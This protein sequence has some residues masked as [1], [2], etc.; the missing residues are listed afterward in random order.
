MTRLISYYMF[1][2]GELAQH[3]RNMETF[4]C[5]YNWPDWLVYHLTGNFPHFSQSF[6]CWL[7]SPF[8]KKK[9]TLNWRT[10]RRCGCVIFRCPFSLY[11]WK[12]HN[13]KEPTCPSLSHCKEYCVNRFTSCSVLASLHKVPLALP[14][15]SDIIPPGSPIRRC[16][17]RPP[18]PHL[19]FQLVCSS[20][21]DVQNTFQD[22]G[23]RL[24][25]VFLRSARLEF[26]PRLHWRRAW[27]HLCSVMEMRLSSALHLNPPASLQAGVE[28]AQ[29]P[30]R[31][32]RPGGSDPQ[33]QFKQL[34]PV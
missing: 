5:E 16:T 20:S 30:S 18:A 3:E 28:T 11:I 21:S 17:M 12:T 26:P 14:P 31:N 10:L 23:A 2:K 13:N 9:Y 7:I 32:L 34:G 27:R 1:Q 4:W 29:K 19:D 24:S 25:Q 33:Q 22:N 6:P 15:L 8:L